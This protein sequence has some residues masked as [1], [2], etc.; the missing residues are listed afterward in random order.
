MFNEKYSNSYVTGL[1]ICW[2]DKN[3]GIG[4]LL[5]NSG[6]EVYID[7]SIKGFEQLDFTMRHNIKYSGIVG[8]LSGV[9]CC[10]DLNK[11]YN[12]KEIIKEIL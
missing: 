3:K 4:I 11:K 5:D 8:K 7:S 12:S 1:K 6:N 9:L 10:Y 2:V